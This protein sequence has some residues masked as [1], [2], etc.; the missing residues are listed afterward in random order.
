[1]WLSKGLNGSMYLK[2]GPEGVV[3][4]DIEMGPNE[5]KCGSTKEGRLK[6]LD[7]GDGRNNGGTCAV[8]EGLCLGN[9]QGHTNWGVAR[10]HYFDS[11]HCS[12]RR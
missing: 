1:M 8:H 7:R 9:E 6:C 2:K 3:K 11:R 10:E 4:V 12:R 5:G